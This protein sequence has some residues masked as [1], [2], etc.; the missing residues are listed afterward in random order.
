MATVS[1]VAGVTLRSEGAD[2]RGPCPLCGA[3]ASRY[4]KG[5]GTGSVKGYGGAF[6]V[7]RHDTVWR[8]HSCHPEK[9]DVIDLEHALNG[10]PGETLRDAALRLIG[11]SKAEPISQETADRLAELD[12]INEARRQFKQQL[13][14]KL[15]REG[16]PA[17]GTLAETY[18]RA[19]GIRGPVLTNMLRMLRFHPDAYHSGSDR[20]PVTAPAAIGLLMTPW[21]PTG[22][23][24][25]TYLRADG[26]A[27]ADLAPAKRNWGPERRADPAGIMRAGGVWLA[28]PDAPGQLIVGEG[29]ETVAS[30]GV[31]YR[32]DCRPVATNGLK[33]LQ[34]TWLADQG[35]LDLSDIRPNP[36]FPAFTW[37][38]PEANPWHGPL[39]CLDMDMSPIKVR[40]ADGDGAK[41]VVLDGQSRA[42]ICAV[43]IA[44]AWL[45]AGATD[46]GF[47]HPPRD[48]DVNDQLVASLQGLCS[49]RLRVTTLAHLSPPNPVDLPG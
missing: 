48:M 11:G 13:A 40:V 22:G 31:L 4:S 3:S 21:G 30:A 10:K 20:D 17:A 15:W 39:A 38:S 16:R 2:L 14:I 19:R 28:P 41:T 27:K 32:A 9:G 8:C 25:A 24:T 46:C 33:G 12:R 43:L 23:V 7:Q 18:Y 45:E 1:K 47:V 36:L 44:R 5:R 29:L 35:R 26:L 34:G 49:D 6:A 37:P 42:T